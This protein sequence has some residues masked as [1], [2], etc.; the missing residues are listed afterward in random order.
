MVMLLTS[1]KLN[2]LTQVSKRITIDM[3]VALNGLQ[4]LSLSVATNS[5]SPEMLPS[6]L[7]ITFKLGGISVSNLISK[8]LHE[9]LDVKSAAFYIDM[10]SSYLNQKRCMGD[11]PK[12]QKIGNKIYYC[13]SELDSWL[14]KQ[15]EK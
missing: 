6:A 4:N 14:E 11:G 3:K 7:K 9:K 13:K 1:L 15:I 10:S 2:L 12:Y 8:H 5:I